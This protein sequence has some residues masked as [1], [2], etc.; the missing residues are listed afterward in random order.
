MNK[1]RRIVISVTNKTGLEKFK[2]LTD[3]GKWEVIST[4]GTAKRLRELGIPCIEVADLTGY[5]EMLGGRV[6][7][8]HPAIHG[9]ILAERDN[10]EH[11]AALQQNC[12]VAI[13]YY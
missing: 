4:G 2:P 10:T 9:G 6:R 1:K 7:T 5:P 13:A 12:C 8:L 11:D 3:S